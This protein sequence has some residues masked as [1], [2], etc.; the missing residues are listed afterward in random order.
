M[1]CLIL[2][3]LTAQMSRT[4]GVLFAA[5][6]ALAAIA[7]ASAA[8]SVFST[9]AK[10]SIEAG[11][12]VAGTHYGGSAIRG[13]RT[14]NPT[15]SLVVQPDGR[16]RGRAGLGVRCG[17]ITWAPVF[18]RLSGKLT[19]APAF[20]VGGH[21]RLGGRTLRISAQGSADGLNANGTVR[22]RGRGCR[23]WRLPFTLRTESALAGAAA[24]P[25]PSST[26]MGL[27]A[28]SAGGVR[29]PVSVSVT[30]TGKMWAIWDVSMK[31]HGVTI[32]TTNVTPYT[33][34]RPDGSFT[35]SERFRIR[36]RGG[37]TDHYKVKL[38]GQFR[39]D[40]VSGTLRAS[41]QTT[42]PGHRYYPCFSGTQAWAARR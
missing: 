13:S 26:F 42:K 23:G 39:A 35:R 11:G 9:V 6:A 34:I 32:P 2:G 12:V 8:G 33:R 14:A 15:I 3:Y 22:V 10:P 4:I 19:A 18:V 28:Q 41:V 7:P 25:P 16:V 1:V 21:T 36:Y 20:T 24:V 37:A 30:H 40:G 17:G 5:T 27:T 38:T 31:C 29:L